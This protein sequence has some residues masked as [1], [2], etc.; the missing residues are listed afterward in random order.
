MNS[1]VINSAISEE[2][3]KAQPYK[4]HYIFYIVK[5]GRG[6]FLTVFLENIVRKKTFIYTDFVNSFS[7]V[8][9][10]N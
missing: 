5:I 7:D 10:F 8:N 1:L 9:N 6:Y 3:L 4:Y 2:W